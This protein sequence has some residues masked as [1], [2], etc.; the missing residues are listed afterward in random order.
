MAYKEM[1]GKIA[2]TWQYD[3][4][5]NTVTVQRTSDAQH[6]IDAVAK[7]NLAGTTEI[8]GLGRLVG[9]IDTV[10]AMQFCQERGIPWERFLYGC[11]PEWDRELR[12]YMAA[13]PKLNY[14]HRQ[15][16]H[17]LNS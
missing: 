10:D 2:E 16:F 9:E 12:A 11:T 3:A 1:I 13:R 6:V 4:A 14:E 5:D 15:K 8:P 17:G 7:A